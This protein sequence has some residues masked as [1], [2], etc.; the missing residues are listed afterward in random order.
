MFNGKFDKTLYL[1]KIDF[2][3]TKPEDIEHQELLRVSAIV[4]AL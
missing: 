1:F 2:R 4:I 3:T